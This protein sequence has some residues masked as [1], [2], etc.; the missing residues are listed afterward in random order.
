MQNFGLVHKEDPRDW[1]A[2]IDKSGFIEINIKDWFSYLPTREKQ[3]S[4]YFDTLGC[5][6][7]AMLNQGEAVFNHLVRDRV[8]NQNNINWLK[9]KGYIDENGNINFS[10]RFCLIQNGTYERNGND[11]TTVY[12]SAFN[13]ETGTGLIP[14][15]M[16]PYPVEQRT[17]VFDREDYFDKSVITD[18][19]RELGKEFLRR[20]TINYF[21]THYKDKNK[22]LHNSPLTC[23]I[24]TRC[25][26]KINCVGQTNHAVVYYTEKLKDGWLPL[27]DSYES[28]DKDFIRLMGADYIFPENMRFIKIKE[29]TMFVKEK[30]NN[31]VYIK[32]P[33]NQYVPII[34]GNVIEKVYGGFDKITV[35]Q[36]DSIDHSK[37]TSER[38]GLVSFE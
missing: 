13:E 14:E 33:S 29:K 25:T 35:T 16:L 28:P 24:R 12:N 36:V 5:V 10:D 20:F 1:G 6:T 32:T 34:D 27:F 19:I 30:N 2:E 8:F 17:P 3:H 9:E 26:E 37:I 23:Y 15:K 31:A 4:V 11:S 21:R 18:E 38:L 7:F 22:Y